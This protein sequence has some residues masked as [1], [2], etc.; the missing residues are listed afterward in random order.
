MVGDLVVRLAQQAGATGTVEQPVSRGG[1][2]LNGVINT[3][4]QRETGFTQVWVQPAAGDA[5]GALGP[6]S[7]GRSSAETAGPVSDP[8]PRGSLL[9]GHNGQGGR[10]D[11]PDLCVPDLPA[12]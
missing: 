7:L 1:V 5:G 11:R 4:I 6:R 3:R 9:R 12:Q 8:V 10:S 2:A